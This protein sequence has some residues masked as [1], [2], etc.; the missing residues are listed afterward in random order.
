MPSHKLSSDPDMP[1]NRPFNLIITGVGGQG[2]LRAAH[3]VS[4][5]AHYQGL[6]VTVGETFGA[7]R[8]GGTVISHIR[9]TTPQS[10]SNN[11]KASTPS[12]ALV[13]SHMADVIIGLEPIETLR[14]AQFLQPKTR[15]LLN[16]HQQL[17]IDVLAGKATAPQIST[18]KARLSGLCS[19]LWT[20]NAVE[21][22]QQAG[23]IKAANTVMVGILA[24]L[25]ITPIKQDAFEKA[26]KAQFV[27]SSVF[28]INE[29][30]FKLGVQYGSSL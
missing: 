9:L 2:I 7:S 20:V 11:S 17:P 10:T 12:G 28:S 26:I 4:Y 19:N 29:K 14:A 16:T 22:A 23:D 24:G 18:I 30:A 27:D 15:V 8:R 3:L 1:D 25:N 5:A 21:L 6:T 13:P